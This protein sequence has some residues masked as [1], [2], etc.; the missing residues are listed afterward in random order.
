MKVYH[1]GWL[2]AVCG[3]TVATVLDPTRST[4]DD[5]NKVSINDFFQDAVSSSQLLAGG[6]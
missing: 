6:A 3:I 1:H 5:D 2:I 4:K